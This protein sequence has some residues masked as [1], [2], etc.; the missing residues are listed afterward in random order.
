M[1]KGGG[2]VKNGSKKEQPSLG[3][4]QE[5]CYVNTLHCKRALG[6]IRVT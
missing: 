6:G 1:G 3:T 2:D 5:Q 4:S